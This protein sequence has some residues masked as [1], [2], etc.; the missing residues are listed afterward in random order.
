MSEKVTLSLGLLGT[1]A[2]IAHHIH[3][4][5]DSTIH[6]PKQCSY[7]TLLS[8]WSS[9]ADFLPLSARLTRSWAYMDPELAFRSYLA[10]RKY[11][12]TT[13]KYFSTTRK[14][15][16][17]AR[18]YFSTTLNICHLL[19]LSNP[20]QVKTNKQWKQTWCKVARI[21]VEITTDIG[22][23]KAVS[24]FRHLVQQAHLPHLEMTYM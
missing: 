12:S 22:S 24:N 4:L 8:V 6:K 10:T 11:F 1:V 15:F 16:S 5:H 21:F 20:L 3:I 9:D 19:P 7:G 13:R 23:D 17:T 14:Y 2:H 18:K